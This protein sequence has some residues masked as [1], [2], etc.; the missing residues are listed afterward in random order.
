ML[1]VINVSV[2]YANKFLKSDGKESNKTHTERE[3]LHRKALSA[4]VCAR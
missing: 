2:Y 4:N 3:S 1:H